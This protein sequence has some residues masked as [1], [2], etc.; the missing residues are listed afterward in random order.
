ML[1]SLHPVRDIRLS[2]HVIYTGHS[3]MEV[4]VK[5]ESLEGPGIENTLMLGQRFVNTLRNRL[6][7][8]S[9]PGR[10]SMV[11][12]DS[13]THKAHEVNPL[14]VST[15]EEESLLNIGACKLFSPSVPYDLLSIHQVDCI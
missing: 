10:F 3:S 2:G 9:F 11:C 4:A 1:A 15:P 5:M 7:L 13:E 8:I 14:V 6:Q 12:R